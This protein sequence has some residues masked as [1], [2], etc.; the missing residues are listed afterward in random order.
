MARFAAYK[1]DPTRRATF[2]V[3][4]KC[5]AGS[6]LGGPGSAVDILQQTFR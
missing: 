1:S 3:P 4:A 5:G 6:C 2:G